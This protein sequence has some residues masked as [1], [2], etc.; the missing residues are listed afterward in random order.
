MIN[1]CNFRRIK[2]AYQ[3]YNWF[4]NYGNFS[5][6]VDLFFSFGQVGTLKKPGHDI[7]FMKDLTLKL[8]GVRSKFK[9][10]FY[11]IFLSKL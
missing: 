5:E 1:L 4:K 6:L 7:E 8:R 9:T 2:R 10:K 11:F 3:L